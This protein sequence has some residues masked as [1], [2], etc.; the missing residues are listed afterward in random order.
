MKFPD[1]TCTTY[2]ANPIIVKKNLSKYIISD[3]F[4]NIAK[5]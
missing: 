3:E 4:F 1:Y 5:P 2:I